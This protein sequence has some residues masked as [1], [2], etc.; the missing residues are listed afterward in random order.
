[1]KNLIKAESYYAVWYFTTQ[2]QLAK[3]LGVQDTVV[4]L[5]LKNN[6]EVRGYSFEFVDGEGILP[7][8]INPYDKGITDVSFLKEMGERYKNLIRCAFENDNYKVNE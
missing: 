5:A 4:S 3:Y 2:A 1:M 6:K 7:A 8:Y